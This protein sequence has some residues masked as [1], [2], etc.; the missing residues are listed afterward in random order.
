MT[1]WNGQVG[2]A[3]RIKAVDDVQISRVSVV[4]TDGN[5]TVIEQGTAQPLDHAWWTYAT[6]KPTN[7]T[8]HL[9]V[10]ALDL[11]GNVAKTTWQNN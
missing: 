8:R 10:T 3:I 7:R 9:E 5:G 6:T 2:Q 11:P 1:A 4:I